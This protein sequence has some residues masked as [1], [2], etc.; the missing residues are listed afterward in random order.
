[1]A[2]IANF[3]NKFFAEFGVKIYQRLRGY[4]SAVHHH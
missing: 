3:W 4:A 2:K 1:M